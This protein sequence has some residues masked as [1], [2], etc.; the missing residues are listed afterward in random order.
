[1]KSGDLIVSTNAFD[2]M[3]LRQDIKVKNF[4]WIQ[5]PKLS[6][7]QA[8]AA[9]RYHQKPEKCIIKVL[10]KNSCQILFNKPMRAVSAGQSAVV[11]RGKEILGGGEIC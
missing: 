11:F 1:M 7:F 2:S 6:E 4:N 8:K 3:I 9:I 5:T 10:N